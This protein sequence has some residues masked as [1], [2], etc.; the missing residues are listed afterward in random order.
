MYFKNLSSGVDP[1][2]VGITLVSIAEPLTP[3]N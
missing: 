2:H 3:D 1:N